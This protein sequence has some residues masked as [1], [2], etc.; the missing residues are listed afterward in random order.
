MHINKQYGQEWGEQWQWPTPMT[1]NILSMPFF[2]LM[3]HGDSR[4]Q[5]WPLVSFIF[6]QKYL[7]PMHPLWPTSGIHWSHCLTL[8]LL[9][10]KIFFFVWGLYSLIYT[11][12]L[13]FVLVV[14]V[15]VKILKSV[16]KQK[17]VSMYIND[18]L[19]FLKV[20]CFLKDRINYLSENSAFVIYLWQQCYY[21][22]ITIFWQLGF[23][24]PLFSFHIFILILL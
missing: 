20:S 18:I 13:M 10:K 12:M 9:L 7:Q 5:T 22:V 14:T 23:S 6:V 21:V 8:G 3:V 2:K 4:K 1:R 11:K 16:L 15:D 19:L 24:F 17:V